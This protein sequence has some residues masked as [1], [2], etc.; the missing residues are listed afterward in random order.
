MGWLQEIKQIPAE[1]NVLPRDPK[2][3]LLQ[4]YCHYHFS[5]SVL[6]YVLWPCPILFFRNT[7]FIIQLPEHKWLLNIMVISVCTFIKSLTNFLSWVVD[8][9]PWYSYHNYY[10]C[11]HSI[12]LWLSFAMYIFIIHSTVI[13]DSTDLI[14]VIIPY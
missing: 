4:N 8:S 10:T 11:H 7:H 13:I 5:Y 3:L 6:A 12:N 14:N 1:L 9:S 2:T